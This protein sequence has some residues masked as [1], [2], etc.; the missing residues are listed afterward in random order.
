MGRIPKVDKER[1]LQEQRLKD[2]ETIAAGFQHQLHPGLAHE[3][4]GEGHIAAPPEYVNWLK[5]PPPPPPV[6]HYYNQ[7]SYPS[8]VSPFSMASSP[9]ALPSASSSNPTQPPPL[10][11]SDTIKDLIYEIMSKGHTDKLVNTLQQLLQQIRPDDVTIGTKHKLTMP[12]GAPPPKRHSVISHVD[13]SKLEDIHKFI[14]DTLN[15][16]HSYPRE[17]DNCDLAELDKYLKPY[18][19]PVKTEAEAAPPREAEDH[20]SSSDYESMSRPSPEQRPPLKSRGK[21]ILDAFFIYN[22]TTAVPSYVTVL[23]S[24]KLNG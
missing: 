13:G 14:Q 20:K 7:A 16:L 1:A 2:E 22:N 15:N 17:N 18:M 9:P 6:P 23:C 3:G 24:L 8:D 21:G 5:P 4:H 12:D 10:V 11:N 19:K